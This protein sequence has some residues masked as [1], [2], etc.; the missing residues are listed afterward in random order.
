MATTVRSPGPTPASNPPSEGY[1]PP[2]AWYR[3]WFGEEYLDLY[4]YRDAE[5]AA[6]HVG[7][8][9]DRLE[10]REPEAVLDLACGAGRHT[11]ALRS[12]GYRALGLDISLTL[13][14]Q[15]PHLPRVG[16]DMCCLPFAG[17]TFDWVLNFFTSF[18]YFET[19][20]QNFQVLAEIER[21]LTRG[22]E[23]LIDFL[24]LDHVLD[25]LE[26]REV[27][28]RETD[29][30]AR[31]AVIERWWDPSARRINKRI[32]VETPGDAPRSFLESVRGYRR[33]E[34][35]MGLNW[36]GLEVTDF[37]GNFDGD[38]FERDSERLILVG[39]KPG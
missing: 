24:N 33:E 38:P 30:G 18:G 26:P 17:D 4:S 21:V 14:A 22:G 35:V 15:A 34:V 1:H 9:V 37:Y 8:V 12:R 31:R 27:R 36:A 23:F 20:R 11:E 39:R 13:L 32:R 2:V 7:F 29:G 3:E 6:R 19:E 28:S 16:G 5:E 25:T 10:T